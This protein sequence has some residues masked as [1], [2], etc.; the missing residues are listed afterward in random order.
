MKKIFIPIIILCFLASNNVL[1]QSVLIQ[2]TLDEILVTKYSGSTPNLAGRHSAGSSTTPTA[3]TSSS[4]LVTFSGRGHT[5]SGFTSDKAQ[6]SL[7][8]DELFSPTANGTRITFSTTTNGTTSMNERM[9]IDNNGN[10][11]IGTINP[12]EKLE[13]FSTANNIAKMTTSLSSGYLRFFMNSSEVT[14]YIGTFNDNVNKSFEVGT[15]GSNPT[16]SFFLTTQAT[17]RLTVLPAGNIGI[18]TTAPAEKLNIRDG[19]ILLETST[20]NKVLVKANGTASAGEVIMY[21]NTGV[22]SVELRASDATGAAGELNFYIPSSGLKTLEID[23]DYGGTG[24]SRIIV[25]QLQIKGGSDLAEFFKINTLFKLE[26][27]TVVSVSEDNSGNL[28]LSDKAYDK[29]VVGIISGANGV[30]T[31]LMLHQKGN[32]VV[33]GDYP[34]AIN[35]RVYVKADAT[36]TAINPGD[37]LTSSD[38]AGYAMKA[39][40]NKK[41]HG[42]ILGKALTGLDKSTGLVLVLLGVK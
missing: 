33:D 14:G 21:T 30:S 32:D 2:P 27:G 1:S 28:Q 18:G 38:M 8:A 15:S 6:I 39:T 7:T 37:L 5:G 24:K 23:G 11:G 20:T 12:A 42:A 35:G 4:G 9:R 31:G 29:K 25:D 36:K 19:N 34:I 41:A 26:A 3:T 13:V 16:G 17:P 10:V 22:K 40:K